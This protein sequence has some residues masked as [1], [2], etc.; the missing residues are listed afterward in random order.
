MARSRNSNR[1][2]WAALTA[3]ITLVVL[4]VVSLPVAAAAQSQSHAQARPVAQAGPGDGISGSIVVEE[5]ETVDG[6]VEVGSGSVRIAEGGTVEGDVEAVA[7]SVDVDGTVEGDAGLVAGS[8]EIDEGATIGGETE[9]AAGSVTIDGE[10]EDDA[11]VAA[12]T[13]TLGEAAS[14]DGDLRYGGSLEGNTDAVA[15]DVTRDSSLVDVSPQIQPFASYVLSLYALAANLLLGAALLALFP[16]FSGVVAD[17]VASEPLRS[18]LVGLVLLFAVPLLLAALIVTIVGIPLALLGAFAFGFVS[19]IALVYGWFAVGSWLLSAVDVENR[20]LALVVGLVGGAIVS[21]IPIVGGLATLL[22]FLLGLGGLS[23]GLVG[24]RRR[25]RREE[26]ALD[27]R[28]PE[29]GAGRS[30]FE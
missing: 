1:R 13:T 18:G 3:L 19:W 10:L 16:R 7:G 25:I 29:P 14:I 4:S 23:R 12:E 2:K 26:P 28:G 22:V 21:A 17:R 5:G 8:V 15:G 6:N 20:W 30:R 27:A 11:T 24:H 9:I